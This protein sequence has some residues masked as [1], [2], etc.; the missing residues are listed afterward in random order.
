M[1]LQATLAP[2]R[3]GGHHSAL[4]TWRLGAHF[5]GAAA[6]VVVASA[7]DDYH[8]TEAAAVPSCAVAVRGV[9]GAYEA[10]IRV[11]NVGHWATAV[12]LHAVAIG[13]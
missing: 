1:A 12:T 7:H 13:E 10:A 4:Y 6:P 8:G 3:G 2:E 9:P 5:T 11:N